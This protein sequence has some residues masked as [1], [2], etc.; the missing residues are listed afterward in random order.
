MTVIIG[1]GPD[2][3]A[4][5][6]VVSSLG[7]S[8]N[9]T[10]IPRTEPWR[11]VLSACDI[12]IEPRQNRFFNLMLLEALSAGVAVAG[13][14]GGVDDLIIK[15]QTAA[16][17]E[18]NDEQNIYFCIRHFLDNPQAARELAVSAQN[19]VR[20]NHTVSKMFAETIECYRNAQTRYNHI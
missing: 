13:C 12:F 11:A 14:K 3:K 5:R 9:I 10:I 7:I 17:L 18:K 19:Y 6:S 20:N 8:K 1:D 2:E 16:I 4:L 15:G